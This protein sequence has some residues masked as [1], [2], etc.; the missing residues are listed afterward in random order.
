MSM[1]NI[2]FRIMPFAVTPIEILLYWQSYPWPLGRVGCTAYTILSEL[3]TYV[4]ILTM[5]AFAF[6]RYA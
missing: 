1:L 6:E 2:Y 5:I 4:S 3:V